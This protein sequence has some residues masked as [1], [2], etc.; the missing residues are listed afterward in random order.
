MARQRAESGE[1]A[2]DPAVL[3]KGFT[4]TADADQ[5]SAFTAAVLAWN[6]QQ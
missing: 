4:S 2:S 3:A 5:N 1:S 6:G